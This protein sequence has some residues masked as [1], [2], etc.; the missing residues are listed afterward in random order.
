MRELVS[1]SNILVVDDNQ[2]NVF[3][4]EQLLEKEGRIFY[5][6]FSGNDA[7][8]IALNNAIDLIILDV[9]M[10]EMDGFEVAQVL[11]SNKKTNDIPILF[12][13]AI[14]EHKYIMKGFGEGA[15]DYLSK[16]LDPEITK[17]KVSV[18]LKLQL[19]KRELIAKNLSLQDAKEE[20]RLLNEHLNSNVAQLQAANKELETFSYSVSHDLKSPLRAIGGFSKILRSKYKAELDAPG[21]MLIDKIQQNTRKMDALIDNLLE[22]SRLAQQQVAKADINME[23]LVSAITEDI[24]GNTEH[25]A[26]IQL[27]AL[28]PACGDRSLLTAVWMNLLLNAIKYSSK[29]ASPHIEIS[30]A[31]EGKEIIYS[32]KDNGSGFNMAYAHKLFG[33]FERLHAHSE[34]Q[35]TGIGLAI[36][37]RIIEKH[38]GRVWAEGVENEGAQFYFSLP[39]E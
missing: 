39:V 29:K 19:Q 15:I 32:I 37:Q 3:A 38:G 31:A 22:F 23:E 6:A 5:T 20:I 2:A 11:K 18:F 7:L 17:A 1:Q 30:S 36:V 16:P 8:L 9:Q 34:F 14:K 4:L 24:K 26:N 28:I 10:P 33:V 12:A 35:G 21:Q 25:N 27:N 13:S